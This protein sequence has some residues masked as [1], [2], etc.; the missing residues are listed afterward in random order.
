MLSLEQ[1][2]LIAKTAIAELGGN[3]K[4]ARLCDIKPQSVIDWKNNGIPRARI[5]YL[6][7]KFPNLKAWDLEKEASHA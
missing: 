4:V 7:L 1:K 6:K 5:P 2:Q 3:A